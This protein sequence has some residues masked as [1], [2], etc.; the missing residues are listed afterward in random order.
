MVVGHLEMGSL[1][2]SSELVAKINVMS[3][4]LKVRYIMAFVFGLTF[5]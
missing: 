2:N 5:K 1:K 4:F 3:L